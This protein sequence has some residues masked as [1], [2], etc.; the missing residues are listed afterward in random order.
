M[1]HLCTKVWQQ[2]RRHC[3]HHVVT[4][5]ASGPDRS[6]FSSPLPSLPPATHTANR[7]CLSAQGGMQVDIQ[8]MNGLLCSDSSPSL[9]PSSSPGMWWDQSVQD[10]ATPPP[11]AQKRKCWGRSTLRSPA[12]ASPALGKQ[13]ALSRLARAALPPASGA[14]PAPG[15]SSDVRT[16]LPGPP[17]SAP[18]LTVG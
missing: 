17:A 6:L 3:G 13:Q 15:V 7:K 11:Q 9:H 8:R 12:G 14:P 2:R 5:E 1:G 4:G 18:Y 10:A 16:H